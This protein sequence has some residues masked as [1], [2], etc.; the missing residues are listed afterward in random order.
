[1][2]WFMAGAKAT[3][4]SVAS[5]NVVS[6]ALGQARDQVGGGGGNEYQIGPFG[7]FDVAH[8]GF[9]GR[10]EKVQMHRV[11]RQCLQ[12]QRRN[13]FSTAAGHDH[14]HFGALFEETTHQLG[15][16][17]GGNATANPE[18]DAFAIQPLHRPAF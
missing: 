5:T 15:A 8:G 9:G 12:G 2:A 4:A 17:V 18:N 11:S 10:V 1:M 16:L 3:L 7:Q 13:E 6:H 14:A